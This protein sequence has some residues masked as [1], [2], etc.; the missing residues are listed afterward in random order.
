MVHAGKHSNTITQSQDTTECRPASSGRP[1]ERTAL[2]LQTGKALVTTDS[3]A[4]DPA[5]P[6]ISL[7]QHDRL[8]NPADISTCQHKAQFQ[9]VADDMNIIAPT[10]ATRERHDDKRRNKLQHK[11]TVE[12]VRSTRTIV[13]A[14]QQ[15]DA[16]T[17]PDIKA[18]CARRTTTSRSF[19]L[20]LV[21]D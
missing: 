2:S 3:V 10:R 17:S 16:R 15:R 7:S 19:Q 9:S 1:I 21:Y 6:S 20:A 11:D 18:H 14:F 13:N 8:F 4:R 12:D 5:E